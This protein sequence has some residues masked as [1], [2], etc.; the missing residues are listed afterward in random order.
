MPSLG[1]HNGVVLEIL[2]NH[3]FQWP[4]EGSNC[5]HLTYNAVAQPTRV[6][7]YEL[8]GSVTALSVRSWQSGTCDPSSLK[9]DTIVVWNLA[10]N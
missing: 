1:H 3:K 5:E 7:A 8:L 4:Q 2:M 9:H 10:R 6:I